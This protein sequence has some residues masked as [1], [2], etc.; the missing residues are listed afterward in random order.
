MLI[1][2]IK[3]TIQ[4]YKTLKMPYDVPL[5]SQLTKLILILFSIIILHSLIIA[6]LENLSI[7]DALWLSL[8]TTT[9]VGY[10]D[11]AP[12]T[13]SG[14]LAT[15]LLIYIGGIAVVAE[16]AAM[17]FEYRQQ[18]RDQILSGKKRWTM[19]NHIVFLNNPKISG[20]TYFY[21]VISELRAS[22][23]ENHNLPIIIVSDQFKTG[24]PD[25]I[26]NLQT[27]YVNHNPLEPASLE[28]ANILQAKIIV[29]LCADQYKLHSDS[30]NFHLL[31]KLKNMGV[32]SRIIAEVA[33]D[34]N[35]HQMLAAGAHSVIRP[36]RTYPEIL[37]RSIVA[38][39][40]ERVLENLFDSFNDECSRYQLAISISWST[41]VNKLVDEEIGIPIAYEDK[42]GNIITN[43]PGRNIVET[44][45][46]FI[47]SK[48][49]HLKDLKT[50]NSL[51]A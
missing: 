3:E 44:R 26:K 50:I 25:K 16:T 46:I 28:A 30:I 31:S 43:P 45:A 36:I 12:Q 2:F 19:Q 20:E 35:R 23:L 32:Q 27:V 5:K 49:N 41:L 9:T 51:F 40:S 14:R 47:I 7:T 15:V 22:N 42:Q 24:L 37:V 4:G 48:K 13:F 18:I 29:L 6:W 8:T 33:D 21:K 17:Y 10:G 34:H 11:I 38:P 39:G 1:G